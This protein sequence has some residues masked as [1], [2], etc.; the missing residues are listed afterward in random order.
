MATVLT[1]MDGTGWAGNTDVIVVVDPA[2]RSLCWVPRDLW[3]DHL[4]DRVNSAFRRGRHEGL[5]SALG[6]HAI[7]VEHSV[8][9]RREATERAIQGLTVTVPVPRELDFWYP[10]SPNRPIEESRKLVS[11]RPPSEVL[12]GER[13][14]HW[15]GARYALHSDTTDFDRIRRQQV[16]LARL[17]E[18]RFE[19]E[20]VLSDPALVARSSDQAL[21]ELRGVNGSWRL[22]TLD[23]VIDATVDGKMVLLKWGRPGQMRRP[24]PILMYHRIG[25]PPPRWPW[26]GLYVTRH[27]LGRQLE[28][29]ARRG[30]VAVTQR[31]LYDGWNAARELPAKPLVV[32]FD[33]GHV[34][35]WREAFPEIRARGWPAVLN[36][37]ISMLDRHDGLSSAMVGELVDAGWELAAH[38]RTHPDLTQLDRESLDGE[39]SGSRQDLAERFGVLADFFCYPSGR[40]SPRVVDSVVR[41]GYLGATTTTP[42][43]A[44]REDL[45][46]MARV[47]VSREDSAT[48]LA[49]HI[50]RLEQRW[51]SDRCETPA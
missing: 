9:L 13:I 31:D 27:D 16:L 32:S 43:L 21:A 42:G 41:A 28:E 36:L 10:R 1:I 46:S 19:F 30:Y 25:D 29:L 11:F 51:N 48:Q 4:G 17:F 15:I 33:D 38:S 5:I 50:Q 37:D 6:E 39:I 18:E 7:V 20:R 35:V 23:D 47:R 40:F 12:D 22:E 2:R 34:S 49:R 3:C 44:T 14:H 26:P 8:C 24:F 45:Y